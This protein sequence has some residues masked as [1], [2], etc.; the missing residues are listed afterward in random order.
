MTAR[1]T[2]LRA[3]PDVPRGNPVELAP[4]PWGRPD[5]R[6]ARAVCEA[7]ADAMPPIVIRW[8]PRNHDRIRR[9]L[10][11]HGVSF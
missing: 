6:L 2:P 5:A 9:W 4:I 8:N 10:R 3:V 11:S 1:L 7:M